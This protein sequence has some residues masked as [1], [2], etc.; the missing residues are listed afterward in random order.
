[1]RRRHAPDR[2]TIEGRIRADV[3][4]WRRLDDRERELLLVQTEWLLGHKH[5]EGGGGLALDD[6]IR[7]VVAAQASLLVL[8]LGTDRYR[9]VASIIVY[10][11]SMVMTGER[12]GPVPGTRTDE[13]VPLH[14]LSAGHRGPVLVAW[15]QAL[16]AARHPGRN[17]DVVL[18]EFA[19]KLDQL[20]GL[21]DGTPP[22]GDPVRTR[23]IEVCQG[24]YD[25]LRRGRPHPPL[26]PYGATNPSEFFAVATESFFGVPLA[27]RAQ[28][29]DLYD[30]LRSYYGQDVAARVS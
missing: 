27:L 1:M 21:M 15:D 12:A 5:W 10:P 16:A 9:D 17:H 2:T 30:V 8:E 3:A 28:E 11:S 25:D 18:H 23:W 20:D 13:R 24:L 29:P 4:H 19:H 6:D 7:I 22:L 26:R 14:G